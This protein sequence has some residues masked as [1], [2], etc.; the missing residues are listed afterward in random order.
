MTTYMVQANMPGYGS[1][2]DD[3]YTTDDETSA[4]EYLAEMIERDWGSEYDGAEDAD[5]RLAIEGRYLDAHAEVNLISI[6]GYVHVPGPTPTHLGRN[7]HIDIVE[8][9][10]NE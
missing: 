8:D 7:Y 2:D 9:E 10:D 4:R 1:E 6:P 3:P 5:E